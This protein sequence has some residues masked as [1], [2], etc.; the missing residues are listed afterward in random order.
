MSSPSTYP[1]EGTYL[2]KLPEDVQLE[3]RDGTVTGN[4]DPR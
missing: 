1:G 2:I 4:P 3:E